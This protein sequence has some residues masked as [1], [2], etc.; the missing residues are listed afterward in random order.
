MSENPQPP[1]A[2][3][4]TDPW[5]SL[6]S[7]GENNTQQ[8]GFQGKD[9]TQR[10][11]RI[12][13]EALL[14]TIGPMPVR[15]F[16]QDFLKYDEKDKWTG[17]M[18]SPEGAFKALRELKMSGK[19]K[20]K[21]YD[22]YNPVIEALGGSES[23]KARC[24]GF[25][26]FR[27]DSHGD[28]AHG[29]TAALKP[30][31]CG[32]SVENAKEVQVEEGGVVART[33]ISL[34]ALFIE[35]KAAARLDFFR[36]P[37]EGTPRNDWTFVLNLDDLD[38]RDARA[39]VKQA[40]GQ[41]V[42]Y[43]VEIMAR[44]HRHCC[45]SISLSGTSARLIRWDRAGAIVT[46]AFDLVTSPTFLCEFLWCFAHVGDGIRGYDLTVR[47]ADTHY[48]EV[49]K[50]VVKKYIETQT[51]DASSKDIEVALLDHYQPGAVS[52]LE[53]PNAVLGADGKRHLLFSRPVTHPMSGTGRATRGYWTVDAKQQ[54]GAAARPIVMFLKDTWRADYR[55]GPRE[56][57]EVQTLK[58]LAE[59]SKLGGE[60]AIPNL[61]RLVWSDDVTLRN[62]TLA[63][64]PDGEVREVWSDEPILQS[65]RTQ[66]YLTAD[67]LCSTP[68]MRKRLMV[69][70]VK[71]THSRLLLSVAG[72]PLNRFTGTQELLYVAKDVLDTLAK[73][74]A[75][76]GIVHRDVTP[77]NIIMVRKQ[78]ALRRTGYLIDWDLAC[79][80]DEPRDGH[81]YSATWQF[82][83]AK[84]AV[85]A[86][87]DLYEPQY[88]VESLFYVVLHICL[89][90][91]P[92]QA[93]RDA[94]ADTIQLMFEPGKV[95]NGAT[96]S[97]GKIEDMWA[98]VHTARHTWPQP[99]QSW[100]AG[101]M[102]I[103]YLRA[104][105]PSDVVNFWANFLETNNLPAGDRAHIPLIVGDLA[106]DIPRTMLDPSLS[107]IQATVSAPTP[108][109]PSKRTFK[110]LQ[111]FEALALGSTSQVA[112]G[113]G[114]HASGKAPS[115]T[116]APLPQ[117]PRDQPTSSAPQNLPSPQ[118][119]GPR[120]Y[121]FTQSGSGP[122]AKK[123]R[124]E[125]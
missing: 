109:V 117:R 62:S 110:Q 86:K 32:Y 65:T 100:M 8:F 103:I 84:I 52:L 97:N 35:V 6:I 44:Q 20:C 51:P 105:S 99:L 116:V 89:L 59:A 66:D 31:L 96:S 1:E 34:V 43:A 93:P 2:L 113:G 82:V 50:K 60:N 40:F 101:M 95:L 78:G 30:D 77:L 75:K 4:S 91:I 41:T 83:C 124:K 94:I 123:L 71:R 17:Q 69:R 33:N 29:K 57:A 119:V 13:E 81:P 104:F 68:E 36:D 61:A 28:T 72:Y 19:E 107:R 108:T 92:H 63:R 14:T 39:Y 26:F 25:V 3:L 11:E 18:P 9:A 74:S 102:D 67:W 49:F 90:W 122:P 106:W 53:V 48:E 12:A 46:E 120:N 76:A 118:K 70:I 85:G 112:A 27:T 16:L 37:P 73:A 45:Y 79:K 121:A 88:D 23:S 47:P 22:I 42:A 55:S 125:K 80:T 64:Y 24:P 114:S 21:E 7:I 38:N 56:S 58:S 54:E 10:Y 115:R 15:K 98:R 87:P 5:N 111:E